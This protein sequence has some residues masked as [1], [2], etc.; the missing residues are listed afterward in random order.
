MQV[1]RGE[2]YW[3]NLDPTV[4]SEMKKLRPAIVV[5]ADAINNAASVVMVVPVTDATGKTSPVHIEIPQGEGG[6]KKESVAHCGQ[7]RA[8]DKARLAGRLGQLSLERLE[9]VSQGLRDALNL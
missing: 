3:V 1:T 8:I 6:L 5:S 7:L 2:I 9:E 4:G